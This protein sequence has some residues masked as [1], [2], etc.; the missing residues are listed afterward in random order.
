MARLADDKRVSGFTTNPALCR[1]AGVTDYREFAK[2]VIAAVKGKPVSFEVLADDFAG[3]ERQAQKLALL[4]DNVYVKIPIVT[5]EGITT[6][7]VI[8]N[9]VGIGVKVNVTAVFT[10]EQIY[11]A[12]RALDDSD[13]IVSIFAGRIADAGQDPVKFIR[14]ALNHRYGKTKALWASTREVY[15]VVQADECGC[16]IITC[17]PD[18][19]K[20]LD[21]IG[22]NLTQ[23]SIETV[24]EFCNEAKGYS[25]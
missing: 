17:T 14:Y 21:G 23:R 24:K 13:G 12:M 9:L 2:Q 5:P 22:A 19:I 11:L 15:N 25:L 8:E 20:K 1:K 10:K 4:G 3:M 16:D 18:V 7:S 6:E